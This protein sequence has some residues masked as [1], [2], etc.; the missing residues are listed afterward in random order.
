VAGR[1]LLRVM[2]LFNPLMRELVEMHYLQTTPVVLDDSALQKLLSP[3]KKTSYE[4][5]IRKTLEQMRATSASR[6]A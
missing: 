4:D 3:V 1:N 2:G 5:G 6:A